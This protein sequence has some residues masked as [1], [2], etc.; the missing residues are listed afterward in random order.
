MNWKDPPLTRTPLDYTPIDATVQP[1]TPTRFK[2]PVFKR[3]AIAG[4]SAAVGVGVIVYLPSVA[5]AALAI[6]VVVGAV[7][8]GGKLADRL[9]DYRQ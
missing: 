1:I 5:M 6:A 8:Y 4:L 2:A 3:A 9:N 7:R